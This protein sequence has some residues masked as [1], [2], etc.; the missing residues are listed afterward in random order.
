MNSN[1]EK[2]SSQNQMSIEQVTKKQKSK[3]MSG[4]GN[5]D[6]DQEYRQTLITDAVNQE[7]VP[8]MF[9]LDI[10]C[11]DEMFEYLSLAELYSLGETCTTMQKVT[12]EFLKRNYSEEN[13]L[14]ILW[15]KP[16]FHYKFW[17]L[18]ENY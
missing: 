10:D 11:C 2:N 17:L 18:Q 7:A 5:V 6:Q 1:P 15:P 4:N 13:L 9:T 16:K 12:G 3:K 8:D 14:F